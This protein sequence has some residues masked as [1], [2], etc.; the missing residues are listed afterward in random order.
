MKLYQDVIALHKYD[1]FVYTTVHLT[2]HIT[3]NI[4]VLITF[5]LSTLFLFRNLD[6][7]K[8]IKSTAGSS[9]KT[10]TIPASTLQAKKPKS[11][12]GMR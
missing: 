9:A 8:P 12:F 11:S 7:A 3:A 5:T 1:H 4:V 6:I 10:K 2:A